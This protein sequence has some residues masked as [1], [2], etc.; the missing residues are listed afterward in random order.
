M[1]CAVQKVIGHHQVCSS[2]LCLLEVPDAVFKPRT[3]FENIFLLLLCQT[4]S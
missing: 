2:S 3:D 4:C 1:A